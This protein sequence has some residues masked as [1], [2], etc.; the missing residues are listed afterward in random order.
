MCIA[1]VGLFV[2]SIWWLDIPFEQIGAG[3]AALF[4]FI[5]LMFPRPSAAL[6]KGNGGRRC[7]SRRSA[8]WQ[9]R[10]WR[11]RSRCWPPKT[12][13]PMTYCAFWSADCII[14]G[15]DTLIWALVFVGVI[16]LGPFVGI[17]AIAISDTGALG[18]LFSR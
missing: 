8:R 12:R 3:L 11:C 5:G 17:L 2:L 4:K 14:R 7:R 6:P 16:G 18:K 9:L 15:V 1:F 10:G 13:R